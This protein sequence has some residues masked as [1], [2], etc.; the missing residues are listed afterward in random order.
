MSLITSYEQVQARIDANARSL[1]DIGDEYKRTGQVSAESIAQMVRQNPQLRDLTEILRDQG[2][3]VE[4]LGR[5]YQSNLALQGRVLAAARERAEADAAAYRKAF[6]DDLGFGS[7]TELRE[8]AER[9][10][11]LVKSLQKSY[12]D[13]KLY[14]DAYAGAA[15]RAGDAT[16]MT[17]EA[18]GKA[19]PT[20]K[21]LADSYKILSDSTST[22]ADKAKALKDAE[23]ALFGAARDADQAA[24][25]QARAVQNTNKVLD[26]RAAITAKGAKQLDVNTD[27]GLRLRESLKDQLSAI[28]ATFRANVANGMSIEEATRKHD[29]EVAALKKNATQ[30][31]VNAGAV[32]HLIDIYGKVPPSATT[33]VAIRGLDATRSQ[34]DE[35]LAYQLALR[36]GI[37]LAEARDKVSPQITSPGGKGQSRGGHLHTGGPVVGPGTGTS[38]DVPAME[39][40]TGAPFWL[41]NGEF[42]QPTASVDYY[43]QGFMEAIRRRA[44]PRQAVRG[45]ADGGLVQQILAEH[46]PYP[47]G[48]EQTRIPSR[49][50]V[51]AAVRYVFSTSTW[52]SSPAAQRGDSGVWRAVVRMIQGTGPLSGKFG[53]AY[54]PGDP[55]WHGCVPMDTRILTRR[56]WLTYDDVVVGKDETV[57][58]NPQTGKNEWTLIVALHHYEDA[59]VWRL[60]NS[61]FTAEVTPDHKWLADQQV[62]VQ[63]ET[64]CTECGR[65][66]ATGR[67]MTKH[68]ADVHGV[69]TPRRERYEEQLVATRDFKQS[70]RVHL[71]K[72][73]DLGSR[74]PITDDE[75]ELIGWIFAD[76]Y[77]EPYG[78]TIVQSKPAQVR[79]LRTFMAGFPHRVYRR[80]AEGHQKY[81]V[82]R[83]AL[84][85]ECWQDLSARSK[86]S[87]AE[88]LDFVY[89]LS[90][91]QRRA[92]VR[93]FLAADGTRDPRTSDERLGYAAFQVSGPVAEAIK[94]AA[95]LEG[96]RP[97][98]RVKTMFD[99]DRF[100]TRPLECIGFRTPVVKSRH[101]RVVDKRIADVWCPTTTLGTWT[102]RQ[103]EEI[104]LT[105]NS[106]RAVDWMGYNQDALA[107]FLARQRPLE[108][109]HRTNT[110]DY[111]YTRG[112]DKGSFNN[113]L[114]EEHRNHI[115]IAMR[116]GGLVGASVPFG[117]YDSG[118]RLPQGLSIAYN[119]T[120][121]PEQVLTSRQMGDMEQAA[122]ARPVVQNFYP[123]AQIDERALA[124]M[125]AR[126]FA[127]LGVR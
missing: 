74:L 73:A 14:A 9:S 85:W 70:T 21:A 53:N 17:S 18:F 57:G 114:M 58:Y 102:A 66:F 65:E 59:E 43:G 109:I 30:H 80:P 103:G 121:R 27:A 5:S 89:S 72:P 76:G 90:V 29:E 123:A 91:S 46:Y 119:G 4:D 55:L 93:G 47:V 118:G 19:N 101:L 10:R 6:Q 33:D 108:L 105:G 26:D 7:N 2:L 16:D 88:A 23:D 127:A 62:T 92:F 13:A 32:Q 110:R 42:V 83:F 122:T 86:A 64:V 49:A 95:Y 51:A 96:Y 81:E 69:L 20:V 100:G 125:S 37:T 75:A 111:A 116:T 24:V 77:M 35:L 54:R 45:Y 56:G 117:V 22:A 113:R 48:V 36:T 25:D 8:R 68:R 52:P 38:D 120:G 60:Q 41:S 39:R 98:T 50:E 112:R 63:T 28:N 3:T 97:D 31:G 61:W 94:V 15:E 78:P 79:Y 1:G 82:F 11:E 126:R 67:G 84:T 104:F 106:G 34:L 87:K 107:S 124:M 40:G 71:A 99:K 44:I 12:D 115:H